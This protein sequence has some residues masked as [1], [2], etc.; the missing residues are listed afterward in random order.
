MKIA[1]Y[2]DSTELRGVA[3]KPAAPALLGRFSDLALK[4]WCG[5]ASEQ[6]LRDAGAENVLAIKCDGDHMRVRTFTRRA[7]KS[8]DDE[9][10]TAEYL[11][12]DETP[13]R[14]GDII[15]VSGW[16]LD[17]FKRNSMLLFNHDHDHPIG[18]VPKLWKGRSD[19]NTRAL[20][21]Q[22]RFH[23]A[24]KSFGGESEVVWK[25]VRDGDMP[26]CSVGFLPESINRPESEEERVEMGLGPW[27]V[28]FEKQQLL[29]LSAVTVPA[30]P[31]AVLLKLDELAKSK[32]F[33]GG[34]IERVAAAI[35]SAADPASRRVL[36]PVPKSPAPVAGIDTAKQ[37]DELGAAIARALA[38]HLA[39]IKNTL[40]RG[41]AQLRDHIGQLP[42][43]AVPAGDAPTELPAKA[44]AKAGD[45]TSRDVN[46][47]AVFDA[48]LSTAR[49][50][51][52]KATAK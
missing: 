13:D 38:P 11:A 39:D 43:A 24:D 22:A 40:D 50:A 7:P 16:Q 17:E 45:S 21:A 26:A 52:A 36:V 51:V 2:F 1:D 18:V 47:E 8:I 9:S 41:L 46:P 29:E 32:A 3:P 6:E 48:V 5:T 33:D 20:F 31:N 42:R 34:V 27:G 14:M 15:R 25:L 23:P 28:V 12:S 4:I 30:N 37:N 49:K 10:R 19:D 44:P 35:K